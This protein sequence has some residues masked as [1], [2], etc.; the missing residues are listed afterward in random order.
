LELVK[1]DLDCVFLHLRVAANFLLPLRGEFSVDSV[2][3][4]A[5]DGR[6]ISEA[7]PT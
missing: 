6:L 1:D 3:E 7:G 4:N 5:E 2:V